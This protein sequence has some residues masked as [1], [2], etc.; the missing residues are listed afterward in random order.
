MSSVIPKSVFVKF[1]WALVFK[2][3]I[4]CLF[5]LYCLIRKCSGINVIEHAFFDPGFGSS[6]RFRNKVF[7]SLIS[8]DNGLQKFFLLH[9][10]SICI[11]D[12]FKFAIMVLITL[13]GLEI[14][15]FSYL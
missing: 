8:K 13:K 3:I 1:T 11:F 2:V 4:P 7:A 5:Q 9:S 14:P 10:V 6:D 12:L 15:I